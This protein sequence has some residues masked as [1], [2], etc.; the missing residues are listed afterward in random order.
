MFR[1]GFLGIAA[2]QPEAAKVIGL[3][4]TDTMRFVLLPQA[5]R[6]M[7]PPFGNNT[8]HL[9]KSSSLV[10]VI[11]MSDLLH[12]AQLIYAR[13]YQTIPLLMVAC[14]WYLV[15]VSLLTVLQRHV[16]RRVGEGGK[17]NR[18]GGT[19]MSAVLA[20]KQ[21]RKAYGEHQVLRGVSLDVQPGEVVALIGP[22]GSGK[23]TLLRCM[24]WLEVP[25]S[26][27]VFVEGDRIGVEA[28]PAGRRRVGDD[29]IRRQIRNVG[30]VFQQFNLF[31]HMSATENVALGLRRT[32]RMPAEQARDRAVELLG[33]VGLAEHRQK[34]PG[35][36]WSAT[37]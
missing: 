5:L 30:M 4:R 27:A 18:S 10:S 17:A 12:A 7:I 21:L 19:L 15:V 25:D 23:S 8:I 3:S 33:R 1:A 2:G 36:S 20:G 16:E 37:C 11:G 22:S 32:R 35:Q 24:C 14:I 29:Q 9:L 13:T 26:G 6:I 34:R 31:P 28:T